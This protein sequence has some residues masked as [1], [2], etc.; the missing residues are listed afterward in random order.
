ML[1]NFRTYGALDL[2][3]PARSVVLTGPN[4]AGKTNLLEAMSMV[5]PG[6]GLRGATLAQMARNEGGARENE[7]PGPWAVGVT[8]RRN[9][10]EQQLG[11]GFMPGSDAAVAKRVVRIEQETAASPAALA[12][13]IQ[14]IWLTPF[15]DSLFHD[16]TSERRR[17]LDRLISSF[18]PHHA[19]RIGAYEKAMRERMSILRS[20]RTETAWLNALERTMAEQAVALAAARKDGAAKLQSI[21]GSRNGQTAFPACSLTVEGEVEG[22]LDT[23]P[24][25]VAEDRYAD[26]LREARAKDTESGRTACGPHL[27]DM[28]VVHLGKARDARECSTGE[29]K[30]LLIR[31]VLAGAESAARRRGAAP[32]LLLDEVAAHLDEQRRQ[33]LFRSIADLGAQAWM[34]GTDEKPFEAF[35]ACAV[36]YRVSGGAVTGAPN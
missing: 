25:I 10:A 23:L 30:S 11:A 28:Q 27:T 21:L 2:T 31:L 34:T 6:R 22:L 35:G 20:G 7:Q 33:S 32:V 36:H 12:E 26:M 1:T 15:M 4:G 14:V 16:G 13:R 19:K 8:L 9:G 5:S 3:F 18:E 24:A 29:Q 17:F